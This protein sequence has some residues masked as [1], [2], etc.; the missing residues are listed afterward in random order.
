MQHTEDPIRILIVDDSVIYRKLLTEAVG[1]LEK[2]EVIAAVPRGS[3]ALHRLAHTQADLVLLDMFMPDMDGMETLERIKQDFPQTAVVMIS[4]GS[5]DSQNLTVEALERG[6]LE[7]IPK[8]ESKSPVEAREHLSRELRRIMVMTRNWKL[9][10]GARNTTTTVPGKTSPVSATTPKP[11][12]F[13]TGKTPP[14]ARGQTKLIVIGVS[15]GGPKA[16]TEVI[17]HLPPNLGIPILIVQHMPA[18]FTASLAEHLNRDSAITVTEGKDGQQLK[19][20]EAII[21]PGGKHMV[22]ELIPGGGYRVRMNQ[23]PPVHSCRPAVDVLFKSVAKTFEGTIISLILT[24]MG[25][26]GAD[27]VAAL[28]QRGRTYSIAQDEAS[29][30]V[31]GMPQAVASRGLAD[32]ILPLEQIAG[33]LSFL[34]AGKEAYT[35]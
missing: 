27:G 34:T 15:T 19:P 9:T 35:K 17:P 20:N 16:L 4:G 29:S 11:A 28:K 10:R 5:S 1:E 2:T 6:A 32:E 8:P 7:F 33:R 13:I 23:E 14:P 26:D 24:G 22:L 12:T 18:L 3:I 30:I 31:Y 25:A 21:A